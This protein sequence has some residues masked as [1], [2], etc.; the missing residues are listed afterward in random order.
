MCLPTALA[1]GGP[2]KR[3][4]CGLKSDE[5]LQLS[6]D[7]KYRYAQC[8]PIRKYFPYN[9]LVAIVYSL[10]IILHRTHITAH[11]VRALAF[12]FC[13]KKE[14]AGKRKADSE[15]RSETSLVP[16]PPQFEICAFQTV[17]RHKS[18]NALE[19]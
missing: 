13:L 10:Q 18:A 12:S 8:L 14:D 7:F 17:A 2:Y 5:N 19:A 16:A 6:S 4:R 15:L 9:Q 1:V 3:R 11:K